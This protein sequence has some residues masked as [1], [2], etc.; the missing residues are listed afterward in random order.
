VCEMGHKD[1]Y[2]FGPPKSNTL[3]PV[4]VAHVICTD[5]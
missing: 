5:L 1:L 3:C 4:R 2:W